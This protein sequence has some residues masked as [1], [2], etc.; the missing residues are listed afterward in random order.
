M[1][2]FPR[3]SLFP[4]FPE[5]LTILITI[6]DDWGVQFDSFEACMG[7]RPLIERRDG[8]QVQGVGSRGGIKGE[9]GGITIRTLRRREGFRHLI[10]D[11][12]YSSPNH[13]DPLFHCPNR[14]SP[15]T[16]NWGE[17]AAMHGR[18]TVK[19]PT[20]VIV[21]QY[22]TDLTNDSMFTATVSSYT[23]YFLLFTMQVISQTVEG[24][25]GEDCRR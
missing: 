18:S 16:S 13:Y 21:V 23:G 11:I 12:L 25:W 20:T 8:G 2:S 19:I 7:P 4:L 6:S 14:S 9:G 15:I 3:I 1:Q 10:F 17:R 22:H 24:V 5:N